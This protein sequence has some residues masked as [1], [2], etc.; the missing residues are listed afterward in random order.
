M[1]EIDEAR[2]A[3]KQVYYELR[4]LAGTPD[5]PADILADSIL[6]LRWK[7]G[8]QMIGILSKDQTLPEIPRKD[9]VHI[10]LERDRILLNAGFR[11]VVSKC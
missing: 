5:N 6:R 4:N 7:D 1:T 9:I 10:I 3:I 11:K 2:E 8:S